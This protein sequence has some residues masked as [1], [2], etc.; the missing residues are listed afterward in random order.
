[1][2]EGL[3]LSKISRYRRS[4]NSSGLSFGWYQCIINATLP[5]LRPSHSPSTPHSHRERKASSPIVICIDFSPTPANSISLMR[6]PWRVVQIPILVFLQCLLL[7]LYL[8]SKTNPLADYSQNISQIPSRII[9]PPSLPRSTPKA[10]LRIDNS[11]S[12]SESHLMVLP[13]L[14]RIHCGMG[15][16]CFCALASFCF[17]RKDLWLC[18]CV[19]LV[20]I[21]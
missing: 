21:P 2:S 7:A 3:E 20:R 11:S 10:H 19:I 8:S 14:R 9:A 13:V 6:Q 18:S 5:S 1:M 17:V 16:F 12:N 15:R 4:C